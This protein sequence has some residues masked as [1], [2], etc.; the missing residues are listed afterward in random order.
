MLLLNKA[1][2]GKHQNKRKIILFSK[3]SLK[4]IKKIGGLNFTG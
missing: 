1:I 4:T 3:K 2:E